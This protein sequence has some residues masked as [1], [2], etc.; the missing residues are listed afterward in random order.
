MK[1]NK[2]QLYIDLKMYSNDY[3]KYTGYIPTVQGDS[4]GERAAKAECF[5]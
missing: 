4:S 5:L 2:A 1:R 3:I